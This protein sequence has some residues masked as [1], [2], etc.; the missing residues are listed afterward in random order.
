ME[1]VA[2]RDAKCGMQKSR[3]YPKPQ[4][5]K[6]S[7]EKLW[8]KKRYTNKADL[9]SVPTLKRRA[10]VVL[11]RLELHTAAIRSLRIRD[12]QA[13]GTSWL[14]A[15]HSQHASVFGWWLLS[16]AYLATHSWGT[17]TWRGLYKLPAARLRFRFL[18]FNPDLHQAPNGAPLSPPAG[19]GLPAPTTYLPYHPL[20]RD[21]PK[22]TTM[23]E[24]RN[25]HP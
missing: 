6:V 2:K 21:D 1:N 17:K 12:L 8:R 5:P 7:P 15:V 9:L 10:L 25:D 24:H 16:C 18:F 4:N 3:K 11:G 22:K 19:L 14:K 23:R 20:V 13:I